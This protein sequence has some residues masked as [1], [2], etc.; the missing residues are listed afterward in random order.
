VRACPHC[1]TS[2]N[3]RPGAIVS[4]K[5]CISR[6]LRRRRTAGASDQPHAVAVSRRVSLQL[7]HQTFLATHQ[8][9]LFALLLSSL[10][11]HHPVN[12]NLRPAHAAAFVTPAS[13]A[14]RDRPRVAERLNAIRMSKLEPQR[15][16]I[17][18]HLHHDTDFLYLPALLALIDHAP[19]QV[20]CECASCVTCACVPA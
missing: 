17:R 16:C 13:Q 20:H 3:V 1:V 19:L 9:W 15:E 2:V 11:R 7:R 8:S 5:H 14:A 6:W 18:R 12:M 10:A 4:R